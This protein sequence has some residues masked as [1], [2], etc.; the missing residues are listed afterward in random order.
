MI[1][2]DRYGRIKLSSGFY[3]LLLIA[4]FFK[5]RL[6]MCGSNVLLFLKTCFAGKMT[7]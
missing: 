1:K 3:V 2:M 7:L 4:R 6:P 5:A